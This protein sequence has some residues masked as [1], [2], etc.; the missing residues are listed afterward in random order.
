MTNAVLPIGERGE[1]CTRG[2]SVMLG[3]WNN[4]EATQSAI[5]AARWM[6]TGD[7]AVMDEQGY[8]NIVGRIK[9]MI[10]R[11]GENVYPRE[12]EEFLYTHPKI[13][14]VQVIGVPDNKYGEEIMAWVKLRE[15]QTATPEE[16]RAYCKD[17]IAHYKI[18]RYFKFVD[19][20]PMTVTGKVQKYLMRKASI[21]EL[22]LQDAAAIQ[23]A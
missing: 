14:D 22:Q 19:A 16:L 3:Y 6:H 2:Y 20:F 18:P 12:I 15:G 23:T 21:E 5:D 11:G 17:Q 13:S 10:I 9:D 4:A 1:L 8:V 7:L